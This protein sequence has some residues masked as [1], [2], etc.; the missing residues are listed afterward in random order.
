MSSLNSDISGS[1]IGF[2]TMLIPSLKTISFIP[3]LICNFSRIALGRT[4][5][6]LDETAVT[7][8]VAKCAKLIQDLQASGFI[9]EIDDFG[10]GYSSLNMLKDINANILK[11]DMGFLRKTEN[12]R[13]AQVILN[14]TID[15]AHELGMEVVTE[16]VENKEQLEFL[17]GIGCKL[18]QGYYFDKPMP[19]DDFVKKYGK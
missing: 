1:G 11:I 3:G 2:N 9:V 4:T 14:Y 8:D 15:M 17:K 7:S 10:S 19:A 13:R 5:W 6:P 16:G 12:L 18:Y